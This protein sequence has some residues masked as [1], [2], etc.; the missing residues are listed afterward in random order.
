MGHEHP[1]INIH[2]RVTTSLKCPC[3]LTAPRLLIL[4]AFSPWSAGSNIRSAQFLSPLARETHFTQ[5]YAVLAT[6]ILPISL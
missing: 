4:P 1:A 3:F 5:A 6:R 2:D